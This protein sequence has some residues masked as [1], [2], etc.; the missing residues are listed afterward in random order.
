MEPKVK[1]TKTPMQAL[2]SLM[3]LCARSEKC[4]S[5]ALRLMRGWGVADADAQRVLQ[6]LIA[7]RFIDDSR[8]TSAFVREKINL[9]GWG[10]Y[11]I[12]AA[13]RRKGI[14]SATIAAA[15]AENGSVDM[16][17]RLTELLRRKMRTT[18]SKSAADL[19][20][21]LLRYAAGQGYDFSTARTCVEQLVKCDDEDMY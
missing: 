17:E 5:D 9:S 15:I 13:L 3:N 18:K 8:Y 14:D 20:Q 11:K 10:V 1:R 2:N 4:S 6:R 19:R 7:E 12:T 21:K 16:T